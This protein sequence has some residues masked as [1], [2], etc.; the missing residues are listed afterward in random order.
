MKLYPLFVLL[1]LFISF[2]LC[3]TQAEQVEGFFSQSGHTNNWA[4]LV[5]QMAGLF[6]NG[7]C[8]LPFFI[9]CI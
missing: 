9:C 5:K 8:S 2:T 7:Q 6:N 3:D 1:S 4:V